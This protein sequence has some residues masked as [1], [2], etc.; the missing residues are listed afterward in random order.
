MNSLLSLCW[1]VVSTDTGIVTVAVANAVAVAIA[2]AAATWTATDAALL[3]GAGC[4]VGHLLILLPLTCPLLLVSSLIEAVGTG[5]SGWVQRGQQWD[6]KYVANVACTV[7]W[8]Q[9]GWLCRRCLLVSRLVDQGD[10]LGAVV[11]LLLSCSLVVSTDT[12]TV[13]VDILIAV[14]VAVAN[15]AAIWN[16]AGVASMTVPG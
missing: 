10:M 6:H 14:A 15:A 9:R 7:L 16:V 11:Q 4:T 3:N 13:T 1:L 8:T 2:N 5:W 12:G